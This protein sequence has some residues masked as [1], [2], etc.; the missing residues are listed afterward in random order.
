MSL[1]KIAV[2][3]ILVSSLGVAGALWFMLHVPGAAHRGPLPPLTADERDLARR[4][5]GHVEAIAS[6]PHNLRHYGELERA[7]TYIEATLKSFG[8]EVALHPYV[9]DGQL[10]RNI[11]VTIPRHARDGAETVVIGAHYDSYGDAPGANDNGTGTAALLE[12]ARRLGDL[13]PAR[14]TVWLVFFV[15]EE[16]P[17]FGTE[18]M[19]SWRFARLLA[20]RREPVRAML[21]LET[22]GFYSDAAGSQQYPPPFG[23]FFPST[24]N[25]IA[26]VGTPGTRRLVHEAIGSFR[27]HT[28]FPTIGGV[29]PAVIP[30]ISWSDHWSFQQFGYPAIMVTDTALFRYPHY[31]RP[32]DTPDKVD[33]ERLARVTMG[34]ERVIRD[35]AR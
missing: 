34:L 24:A 4:L 5:Q 3:V 8:Y 13:R 27:R 11:A 1:A 7:A 18:A 35:I 25:F 21:S 26:F 14:H 29:A 28:Q 19:G 6:A 12:L 2:A 20:E 15:N 30:G 9:A 10:V 17:Y 32:S 23:L 31:H 33:Y 16:P 22:L